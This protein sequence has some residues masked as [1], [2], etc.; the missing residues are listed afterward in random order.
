M[1]GVLKGVMS[2]ARPKIPAQGGWPVRTCQLIERV[3]GG[4]EQPGQ[5]WVRSWRK[6]IHKGTTMQVSIRI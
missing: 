5:I 1:L 4:G 2:G 3:L 6:C